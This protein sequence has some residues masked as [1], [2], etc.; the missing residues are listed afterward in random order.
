MATMLA[1]VATKN[2]TAPEAAIPGFDV[3]GKTGTT[4]MILDGKYSEHHHVA[5]F[6]GFFPAGNPQ[7]AISVIVH[8]ADA[9][10]PN[11]IAYGK[12]VAAPSFKRLGEQLISYLDIK[13]ASAPAS[14]NGRS[15]LA[16]EGAGR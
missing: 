2:G 4:Q 6:V 9:H 3:A 1:G 13:P 12:S 10:A 8:D 11:G 15:L 14:V 7:I 16:M 5:S